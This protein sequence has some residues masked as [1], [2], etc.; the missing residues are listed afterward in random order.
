M[1]DFKTGAEG[2][3]TS[4][5]ETSKSRMKKPPIHTTEYGTQYV[6]VIDLITS[7]EGWNEIERLRGANLVQKPSPSEREG[8]NPSRPQE[9]T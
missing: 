9:K 6:R 7:E 1:K 8:G 4:R 2:S 3:S 5:K